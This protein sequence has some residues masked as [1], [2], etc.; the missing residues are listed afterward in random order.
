M[1]VL[2]A[3]RMSG[4]LAEGAR[5]GDLATIQGPSG[6]C[7]YVPGREDQEIVLA[8]T[9]TGLAPLY[10]IV[11]D[12]VRH[13]H[14]APMTL[15]H[16]AR[17]PDGLYLVEPLRDLERRVPWFRYVPCCERRRR[18]GRCRGRPPG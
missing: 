9:G 4:W 7:F 14:K 2:A 15:F 6:H 16:G 17:D 13:G 3:G 18:A 11:Q 1:R 8:G 12:A 5:P 10:G